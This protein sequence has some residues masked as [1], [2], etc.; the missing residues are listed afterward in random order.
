[1]RRCHPFLLLLLLSTMSA[2]VMSAV[3][4]NKF[5]VLGSGSYTRKLI[6]S[7]AGYTFTV[8]KADI[9]ERALGDRKDASRAQELVLLLAHAKADAVLPKVPPEHRTEILLTA[10]QVVV[11]EQRILEKPR[12]RLEAQQ[13]IEGYGRSPCSTVGSI[14]LTDI[15]TGRRVGGVD[16]ATIH[17]DP[18]PPAV[19]TELLDEG[20]VLNCAGG[21]MVEHPKVLPYRRRIDGTEASVMGLSLD[22]L[23]TLLLQLRQDDTA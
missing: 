13:F 18:I 22:L 3:A 17:F 11:H 23:D 9:D 10:D 7:N 15:A 2:A 4:T 6:L 20:E 16:T 8:I 14:V 1:M 12:D 21:L 19:I 5:F